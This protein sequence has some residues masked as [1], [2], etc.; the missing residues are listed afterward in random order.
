MITVTPLMVAGFVAFGVVVTLAAN[1]L[2]TW[3]NRG[4][5]RVPLSLGTILANLVWIALLSIAVA[6]SG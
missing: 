4:A 5:G 3:L 1:W 6:Q 2:V